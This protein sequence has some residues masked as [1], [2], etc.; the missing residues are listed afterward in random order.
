MGELEFRAWWI[1]PPGIL[2]AVFVF[3]L[4]VASKQTVYYSS[5]QILNKAPRTWRSQFAW[6]P[7][8]L[9]AL[10]VAALS[11][12]LA[13]PR[14]GKGETRVSR[15]GIAIMMVMDRSGSMQARDM[16]EEDYS[17]DRL[18]AV[19][20]V[21]QQFVTGESQVA[22]EGRPDDMIGLITFAGYADSVCPLTLDHVNLNMLVKQLEIVNDEM[23]DGTAI[24]DG[25]A[26][27]V[28]RLRKSES[29]SKV[30]I[31]LSDGEDNASV[32]SPE[33][34]AKLAKEND[35]KVYCIGVGTNGAAPFP[36]QDPFSGRIVLRRVQ[37][38]IDEATLKKI[39]ATTDGQYFRATDSEAL[40]QIY[41]QIDQ[42]ERTKVTESRYLQYTEHY[43]PV[44]LTGMLLAI[45]ATLLGSS[46][47]QRLP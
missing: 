11:V 35:I 5:L 12:A 29:K 10:A 34:A 6:L 37:V 15:E 30:A 36:M 3:W 14:T 23:E 47:F 41:E 42:L 21:F 17:V 25:L 4:A 38:N 8:L 24:G 28:E 43:Q 16:V 13:G 26:L 45:A 44:L 32:I 9:M 39:A 19:K 40:A 20:N 33:Q 2:L 22:G 1:I 31:L 27:A 46:L 18:A 7:A